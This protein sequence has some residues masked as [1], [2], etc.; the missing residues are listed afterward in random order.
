VLSVEL[1][2]NWPA[3]SWVGSDGTSV[4]SLK[5]RLLTVMSFATLLR[6]ADTTGTQ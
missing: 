2:V 6:S 1:A 3:M 5:W 4:Q